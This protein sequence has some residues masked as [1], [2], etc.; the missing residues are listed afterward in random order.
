[1]DPDLGGPKTCGSGGSGSGTLL[2]AIY[3]KVG[4][5]YIYLNSK[6][7]RVKKDGKREVKNQE[8]KERKRGR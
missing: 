1:M 4:G 7:R 5:V 8:G 6:E 2:A 3:V